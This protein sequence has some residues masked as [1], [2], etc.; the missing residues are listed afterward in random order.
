MITVLE[1]IGAILFLCMMVTQV[2]IPIAKELP[3]FPMF[4]PMIKKLQDELMEL[5]ELDIEKQLRDEINER[6]EK[7]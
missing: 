5:N 4:N 2:L 6:K 3:L 7:L 1:L